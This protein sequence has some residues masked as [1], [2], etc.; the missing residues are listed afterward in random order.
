[1]VQATSD[2]HRLFCEYYPSL[3]QFCRLRLSKQAHE[4]EDIVH[5]AFLRCLR[6]WKASSVSGHSPAAYFYRAVRSEIIDHAR[7][8]RRRKTREANAAN[9]R[10]S[11]CP[12]E[13]LLQEE[14]LGA[15]PARMRSLCTALSTQTNIEGI[16]RELGLSTGALQ[17]HKSRTLAR[18][19]ANLRGGE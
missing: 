10:R 9:G 3:V 12:W 11:I 1:M 7:S 2:F 8:E 5:N 17:V 18:L 6:S 13:R 19:R 15:L 16:S 14:A 4:A